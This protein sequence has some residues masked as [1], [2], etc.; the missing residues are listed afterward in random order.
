M[1]GLSIDILANTRQAQGE[2]KDLGKALDEVGDSLD[3]VARDSDLAGEKMERTFR[4]MVTDAKKADA[5]LDKVGD[6]GKRGFGAAGQAAGEFKEEAVANLSEVTSS[7]NGSIE[8]AGDLIQGTLGG[9]AGSIP[10]L[11]LAA[12][13]VAAGVGVITE[14]F[15]KAGEAA[16]EAKQDAFS[17]A[18]DVGGALEAAGY[19]ERLAQ[20][21]GDTEKFKKVRDIATAAGWAE[22][23]VV[24]ALASG[25]DKLANLT[26]AYADNWQQ[27]NITIGRALELENTLSGTADGYL[28]G[29][30]AAE[31]A[32]R[33]NYRYAVQAGIATGEVDELGRAIYRLPNDT[34][35]AVS[36]KTEEAFT[37]FERIEK[38]VEQTDGK[39]AKVKV[40]VDDQATKHVDRIVQDI[41]RKTATITITGKY[42]T[43]QLQ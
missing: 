23:D 10:G 5:A 40:E 12:A 21:T 16:E 9:L 18:Y 26:D 24:E 17:F 1:A 7:F 25:G 41:N 3:D 42:G 36:A 33:A 4:D 28:S 19:A 11:G 13:G 37:E 31:I 2:V 43:R 38:K 39:K 20:W 8:S 27:T 6:S 34:E 15:T 29:A 14:A 30:E 35:V 32:S 22:L